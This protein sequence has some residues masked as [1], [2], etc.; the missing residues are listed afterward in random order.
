MSTGVWSI[1]GLFR[2]SNN[3]LFPS[4]SG[5]PIA[6]ANKVIKEGFEHCFIIC[7]LI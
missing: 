4:Q 3:T 7:C 5:Y 1:V 6:L 2:V